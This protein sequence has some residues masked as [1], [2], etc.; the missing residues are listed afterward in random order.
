M[1]V[2]EY[3]AGATLLN[4]LVA[5]RIWNLVAHGEHPFL[6]QVLPGIGFAFNSLSSRSPSHSFTS[7]SILIAVLILLI[8]ILRSSWFIFTVKFSQ[9]VLTH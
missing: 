2:V 5:T 6:S 4:R 3:G 1:S 8:C 9:A 7:R